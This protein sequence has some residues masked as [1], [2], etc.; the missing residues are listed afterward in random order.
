MR[1]ARRGTTTLAGILMLLAGATAAAMD[2]SAP[3]LQAGDDERVEGADGCPQEAAFLAGTVSTA[4]SLY[5]GGNAWGCDSEWG[6]SAEFD[7]SAF[8]PGQTVLAAEFVVR[9]TGHEEG[10]PYVAAFGYGATGGE[11]VLPRDDLD[12]YSALDIV[13]PGVA[14][15]DLHFTITAYLQDLLD[16]GAARAGFFLCGVYSEVGRIDRI[17]VGGSTHEFP[18][19]LILSVDGPVVATRSTWGAVKS[20]Y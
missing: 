9:K 16:D 18:P 7:L 1:R 5:V 6:T 4:A 20:L 13:A 8:G 12:E 17:Y 19:R 10:L 3:L 2:Y 15:V 11:V 14:N